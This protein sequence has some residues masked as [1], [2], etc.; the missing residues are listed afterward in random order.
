MYV[1]LAEAVDTVLLTTE[2]RLA[3]APGPTCQ[4]EVLG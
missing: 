1:A 4:I 3:A 2:L